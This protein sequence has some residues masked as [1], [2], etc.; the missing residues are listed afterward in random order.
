[1]S[2]QELGERL[3]IKQIDK[4]EYLLFRHIDY[5]TLDELVEYAS[6]LFTPFHLT[7]HEESARVKK[8]VLLL[9]PKLIL[10]I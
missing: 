6:E 8:M 4:L 7:I 10:F 3:E 5:F 2:E 9:V 1:L